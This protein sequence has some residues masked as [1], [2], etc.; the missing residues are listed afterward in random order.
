MNGGIVQQIGSPQEIYHDPANLFVGTFI[1]SPQ[2][3]L[4]SC[5]VQADGT[6]IRA[7]SKMFDMHVPDCAASRFQSQDSNVTM[8]VRP[9]HVRL[10][11]GES[12]SFP[13][14]V[15]LIEPLGSPH[16]GLFGDRNGRSALLHPGR[17]PVQ[18][19]RK[20]AGRVRPGPGLVLR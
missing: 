15:G 1:G 4:F 17:D 18:G 2:I 3:N 12:D 11:V 5:G 16:F 8:G 19:R 10:G 14:K 9:E 7:Q 13:A 6:G 20:P